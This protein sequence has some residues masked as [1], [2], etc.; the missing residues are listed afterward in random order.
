MCWTE[1]GSEYWLDPGAGLVWNVA[2]RD[3]PKE[4]PGCLVLPYLIR[5]RRFELL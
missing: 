2:H 4:C 5:L 3:K 1:R